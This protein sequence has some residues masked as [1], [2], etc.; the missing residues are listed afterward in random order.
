MNAK[1]K[2]T[3]MNMLLDAYG[4]LLTSTQQ[5]IM[6]DK[7]RYDLSLQ[8][9]SE[10]FYISRAAALDAIKVASKKLEEYEKKLHFISKKERV[11][12]DGKANGTEM[13]VRTVAEVLDLPLKDWSVEKIPG[14][15]QSLEFVLDASGK[16]RQEILTEAILWTYDIEED[17][18]MLR[19]SPQ[20]FEKQRGAY[21]GRREP[22]AFTVYLQHASPS[23]AEALRQL[24]FKVIH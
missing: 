11:F 12:A 16:S 20:T 7:Y 4:A 9:I 13:S 1:E 18:F 8:E 5:K 17:S 24:G 10:H 14:P 21:P 15:V 3:R 22:T 2:A 19:S 23:M 6:N